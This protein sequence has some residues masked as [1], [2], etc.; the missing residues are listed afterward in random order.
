[1]SVGSHSGL[2]YKL[3]EATMGDSPSDWR[4]NGECAIA[5]A[6]CT[7]QDPEPWINDPT[8]EYPDNRV[9]PSDFYISTLQE[10]I[11]NGTVYPLSHYCSS[12]TP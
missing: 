9:P 11:D 4:E 5:S 1:M 8:M 7:L 3:T 12:L 10:A 6:R 2:L